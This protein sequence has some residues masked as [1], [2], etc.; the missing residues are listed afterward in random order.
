MLSVK[1][2]L[3]LVIFG[4]VLALCL[5]EAV[6]RLVGYKPW[7]PVP[8]QDDVTYSPYSFFYADSTLG[9]RIKP[10]T[11]L[12]T[13][14]HEY[15]FRSTH[16]KNGY[17]ISTGTDTG[18]SGNPGKRLMIF[19]DSFTYGSGLNDNQ[20]YPWLLQQ[21]LPERDVRNYG[22]PGYGVANVYIQMKEIFAP[23]SG[24][25]C[26]YAY[27]TQ[28][29]NRFERSVVKMM[30]GHADIK[31]NFGYLL[32]DNNLRSAFYKYDYRLVP[33]SRHSSLMNFADDQWNH[34][35]DKSDNRKAEGV[36][37]KIVAEMNRECRRRGAVFIL[38][39]IRQ[40][41]GSEDM[42]HFC[43]NNGIRA[44]D[45]SV[46]LTDTAFNQMP[47]DD[48]PNAYANTLF[49]ERLCR[50]LKENKLIN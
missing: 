25:V 33:F 5:A 50:F 13:Y 45:I 2:K 39:A 23:D 42:L 6:L 8:I 49:A 9:H 46:D 37:K 28:H 47:Y 4:L 14:N 11:Y 29:N 15:T 1:K 3:L 44:T 26:I 40:K 24:D 31:S 41:D 36:A 12:I 7:Q 22:V 48:H 21:M 18:Q 38:A 16:H 32:M 30:Y 34:A 35:L 43:R 19:G 17:R 10:G 20:T 27:F